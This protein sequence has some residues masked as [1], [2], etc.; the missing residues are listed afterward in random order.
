MSGINTL[1]IPYFYGGW[2]TG[3]VQTETN[4]P[5]PNRKPN[6]LTLTDP[7]RPVGLLLA[8]VSRADMD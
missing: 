5:N 1:W 7:N 6:I 8:Y 4:H 2:N 3:F